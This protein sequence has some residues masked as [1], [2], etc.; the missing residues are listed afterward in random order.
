M[1]N[2]QRVQQY[3]SDYIDNT[4]E[5][6]L[7]QAFEK[8]LTDCPS[9]LQLSKRVSRTIQV[10]GSLPEQKVS[11][12][13]EYVLQQK[14]RAERT[15]HARGLWTRFPLPGTH[16]Y[17]P[18]FAAVV[19]VLAVGTGLVLFRNN[20]FQTHRHPF[21][22]DS[23]SAVRIERTSPSGKSMEVESSA[24][25]AE[26][27]DLQHHYVLSTVSPQTIEIRRAYRPQTSDSLS[28]EEL[29]TDEASRIDSLNNP[30][31]VRYVLPPIYRQVSST[32]ETFNP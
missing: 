18:A 14:L 9:C 30:S 6:D 24:P 1:I 17:G 8:H 27:E 10:L 5:E 26:R 12:S 21:V 20:L 28:G 29:S 7:R 13:F 31:L 25:S 19:A 3:M 23:A 22:V 32:M 15:K 2:C 16:R 4:L 11:A